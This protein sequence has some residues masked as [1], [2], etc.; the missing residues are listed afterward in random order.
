MSMT[1][2]D[3]GAG[4]GIHFGVLA[5]LAVRLGSAAD[6]MDRVTSSLERAR[7]SVSDQIP[8]TARVAHSAVC[9]AAGVAVI[10]MRGPDQGRRWELRSVF[11]G[12][13]QVTGT[14]A[15]KG[16][17][18]VAGANPDSTQT[19]DLSIVNA[20]DLITQALPDSAF[21]SSDQVALEYPEK[22][23]V[24]ITG[25]SSSLQYAANLVALDYPV[26]LGARSAVAI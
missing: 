26:I 25:G 11:V 6:A 15:G 14:P 8:I 20:R 2:D 7:Q 5:D 9:S 19:G 12:G 10:D 1:D 22:V 17:L 13:A 24:V 23:W 16:Y 21:Y 3:I 18:F 4:L